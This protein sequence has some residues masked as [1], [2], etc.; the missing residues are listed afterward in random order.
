M[1]GSVVNIMDDD[2]DDDVLPAG[3]NEVPTLPVS[4]M[5]KAISLVTG[6]GPAGCDT[7]EVASFG[8]RGVLSTV[9][10]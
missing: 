2:N 8:V 6:G 4:I 5:G 10:P 9:S 1:Q 7:G 3:A